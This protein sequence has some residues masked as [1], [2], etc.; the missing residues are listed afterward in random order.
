MVLATVKEYGDE[1]LGWA[2]D[3]LRNDREVVL[4]AVAQNGCALQYASEELRSDKEVVLTAV[5]QNGNVLN[6]AWPS[7]EL[8]N[9][10]L[11]LALSLRKTRARRRWYLALVKVRARE[12][13]AWWCMKAAGDDAHFDAEGRA[14]MTGRGAKRAREDF[15]RMECAV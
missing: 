9:D 5:A 6:L 14:R 11:L 13:A 1:S 8:R 12:L 2:S 15:A 10:E 4:A 7:V 3:E